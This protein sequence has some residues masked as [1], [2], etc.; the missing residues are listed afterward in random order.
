MRK[1][2]MMSPAA[3]ALFLL[4]SA[5][6]SCRGASTPMPPAPAP[7]SGAATA[8][9]TAARADGKPALWTYEV[10]REYPHDA[11]SYT[12]GLIF[13]EGV[14]YESAGQYGR[15]SLRRVE[16]ETGKVLKRTPV[17]EQFFAEGMTMLGGKLFQLT[18]QENKC[19]VYDLATFN[20]LAEMT[21]AGEGWGLTHDGKSLILSDGSHR[22]RFI[23]PANFQVERTISVYED[24]DTT[25]PLREINE[26]EYVRGEIYANIWQQ[27]VI[28][29]IDPQN[30][31]LLGWIDM[32]GILP[33]KRDD[34]ADAVLNGIAYDEKGQRLFVTG[35][36]WPKLYEIRLK[37]K[38]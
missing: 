32:R 2:K 21:Y 1:P 5:L 25:R 15:S 27:D 12:Q 3:L 23:N 19:F 6:V 10:V 11:T 30:G 37:E 24:N 16:V 36:L 13:H 38:K 8:S 29:R 7:S 26:L 20:K 35:K 9:A 34:E 28:A 33:G 18:W 4:T 14:F 22:I 31:R 17:P